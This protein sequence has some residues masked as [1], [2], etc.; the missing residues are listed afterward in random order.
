V[1]GLTERKIFC[2][3]RVECREAVHR[4]KVLVAGLNVL[5]AMNPD[6]SAKYAVGEA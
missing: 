3:G 5:F 4:E 2:G 1:S 6:S